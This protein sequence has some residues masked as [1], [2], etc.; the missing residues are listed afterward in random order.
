MI[1][2]IYDTLSDYEHEYNQT[3]QN[4]YFVDILNNDVFVLDTYPNYSII[5]LNFH[6]RGMYQHNFFQQRNAFLNNSK[7]TRDANSLNAN[8]VINNNWNN[9][10]TCLTSN[11]CHWRLE[12][13]IN[14]FLIFIWR[15]FEKGP[16]FNKFL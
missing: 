12:K 16:A 8:F 9:Q 11:K 2:T 6:G 14:E 13:L 3:L 5:H 15:Y 10:Q 4:W 1:Q 7:Q